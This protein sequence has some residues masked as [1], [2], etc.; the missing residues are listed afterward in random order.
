MTIDGAIKRTEKAVKR[1][2]K[3]DEMKLAREYEELNG[4]L[5]KL[6]AYKKT[7][8]TPEEVVA[9]RESFD[10]MKKEAVPLLRAKVEDRLAELPCRLGGTVYVNFSIEGDY[11]RM[12][13]R[14]YPCE[15]VFIGL[16][17]EPFMHI[18]F[19]NGRVFPVDFDKIG[20]TVFLTRKEAETALKG[21]EG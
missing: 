3:S 8:L 11:L 12:K 21:Q 18:Q 5:K 14:P 2:R 15:V 7:G 16:S 6:K 10:A 17:N 19:P 9:L 1:C 4:W 20:K 13:D